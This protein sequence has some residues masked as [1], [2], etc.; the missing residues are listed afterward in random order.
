MNTLSP[1]R[2]RVAL[3]SL[4]LLAGSLIA[5]LTVPAAGAN[6]SGPDR[7]EWLRSD[8]QAVVQYPDRTVYTKPTSRSAKVTRDRALA[9]ATATRFPP[10]LTPGTPEVALRSVTRRERGQA[11][12]V[13]ADRLAWVI[14]YRRSTPSIRG[15]LT[16]S[17]DTRNR[18]QSGLYCVMV[19][20]VDADTGEVFDANQYCRS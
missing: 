9:N 2:S 14:T 15:P 16:M 7:P 13:Y 4:A 18:L 5:L 6:P 8:G 1:P 19:L 11:Q 17:R 12:A 20:L 10:D 3:R